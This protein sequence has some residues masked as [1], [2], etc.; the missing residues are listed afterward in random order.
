M[1]RAEAM[2]PDSKGNI[3][4]SYIRCVSEEAME[5]ENKATE[6]EYAKSHGRIVETDYNGVDYRWTHYQF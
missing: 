4:K 1:R 2:E 6:P 3:C 5:P